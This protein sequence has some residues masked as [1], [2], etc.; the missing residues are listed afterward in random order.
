MH[1]SRPRAELLST[2]LTVVALVAAPRFVWS[3][4]RTPL[5]PELRADAIDVRSSRSG[6]FHAGIGLNLPLG[7]Y[8][9]LE[10][11]G[12]GGVTRIDSNVVGS[13]RGDV[14][15]RFLLDPFG[16]SRWGVSFGGGISAQWAETKGWHEYL[17]LVLDL[18]APPRHGV[19]A[20]FQLGLGGGARLGIAVRRHQTGR[21]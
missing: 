18:E 10:T 17:A 21:R 12:A 16:E 11:V 13:A 2:L 20:A 14:V 1:Q 15:A 8:V 19:V 6:T 4:Q 9:R 5:L 7:Y 3:Q